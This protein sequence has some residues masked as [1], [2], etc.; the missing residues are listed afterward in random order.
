MSAEQFT[1]I[2]A[3]SYEG[4]NDPSNNSP[5]GGDYSGGT[6]M[7]SW[8]VSGVIELVLVIFLV[9]MMII[10]L[11]MVDDRNVKIAG[12]V[13]LS[14]YLLFQIG[15]VGIAWVSAKDA[16]RGELFQRINSELGPKRPASLAS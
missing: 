6:I 13:A 5:L 1:D 10:L 3:G 15:A 9:I 16:K 14:V 4:G 12:G 8:G 11:G 7:A 2:L